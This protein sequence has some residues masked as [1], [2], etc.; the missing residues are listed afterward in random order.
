MMILIH[1]LLRS[2][3]FIYFKGIGESFSVYENDVI[4]HGS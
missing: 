1:E 2:S 3:H 4:Y